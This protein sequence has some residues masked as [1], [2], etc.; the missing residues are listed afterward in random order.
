MI[1]NRYLDQLYQ[2]HD[3][4]IILCQILDHARHEHSDFFQN[5]STG[6]DLARLDDKHL[7]YEEPVF[8]NKKHISEKQKEDLVLNGPKVFREH[9]LYFLEKGLERI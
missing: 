8:F 1:T 5:I 2:Y 4:D 6:C 7:R 9:N 3:R